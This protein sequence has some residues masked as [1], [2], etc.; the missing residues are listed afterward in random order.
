MLTA[1]SGQLGPDDREVHRFL[2]DLVIMPR[3]G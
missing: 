3:L 2:D 1:L